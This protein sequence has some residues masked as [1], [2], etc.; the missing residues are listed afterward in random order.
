M[1]LYLYT[2]LFSSRWY[3]KYCIIVFVWQNFRSE[4]FQNE[5]NVSHGVFF[6]IN[7]S[8]FYF[9]QKLFW[10]IYEYVSRAYVNVKWVKYRHMV[11]GHLG[12][13]RYKL[14]SVLVEEGQG[15]EAS[16]LTGRSGDGV[17]IGKMPE[18]GNWLIR[19]SWQN[20]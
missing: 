15:K 19:I 1:N 8:W 14:L 7:Y 20:M 6:Y 5:I 3:Y 2:F 17:R 9:F 4:P 18:N 12:P 11:R 10:T 16:D 13:S